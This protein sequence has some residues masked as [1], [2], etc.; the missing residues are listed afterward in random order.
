MEHD[1]F[2][3]EGLARFEI[4]E[5]RTTCTILPWHPSP[6]RDAGSADVP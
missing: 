3:R 4:V 5:F 6:I 1:P 2:V